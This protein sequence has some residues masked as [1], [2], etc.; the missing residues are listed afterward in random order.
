MHAP[1][2]RAANHARDHERRKRPPAARQDGKE[3]ILNTQSRSRG[4]ARWLTKKGYEFDAGATQVHSTNFKKYGLTVETA[5]DACQSI[6]AGALI[7]TD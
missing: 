7:P 2:R 6:R 3:F 4:G 5:F 1:Q